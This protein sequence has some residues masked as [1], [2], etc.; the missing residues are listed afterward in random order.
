MEMEKTAD[1][2]HVARAHRWVAPLTTLTNPHGRRWRLDARP[3][4]APISQAPKNNQ[5]CPTPAAQRAP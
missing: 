4:Q 5:V 3:C 1:A 2:T